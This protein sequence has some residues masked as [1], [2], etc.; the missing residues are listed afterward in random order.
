MLTAIPAVVAAVLVNLYPFDDGAT[1]GVLVAAHLPVVLWF[2][3][4]ATYTGGEL[5][6]DERRMDVVRFTGEWFIY[7]VLLALGGGVL[8]GLTAGILEPAG[9]D[10][11]RVIEWVL[12]MG[13]AGAVIVAAWLVESKQRVVENMAPVL[14]V[15]FTPLFALML[16]VAAVVY[17]VTGL[18]AGFDRE[19]L[20]VFDVLMVVVL[21]LVLYGMSARESTAGPGWIDRVQLAAV[22]SALVLDVIVLGAMLSR[23]GDL[24][25]TPGPDR[26]PRPQPGPPGGPRRRRVVVLAVPPRTGDL[27]PARTVADPLPARV[28]RLGG[29]RRR[30]AP[31]AVLLPLTGP[32]ARILDLVL[33]D[34]DRW[35]DVAASSAARR[36]VHMP[37]VASP[38]ATPTPPGSLVRRKHLLPGLMAGTVTLGLA[39][40]AAARPDV[41]RAHDGSAYDALTTDWDE[42]YLVPTASPRRWSAT[43]HPRLCG[44]G[45]R[46]H[47]HEHGRRDP[48]ARRSLPLPPPRGQ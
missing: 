33:R 48:P 22:A 40:Q 5:G 8:M 19:L 7:Y 16:V 14:T 23:I 46:P 21:G 45:R 37:S 32:A 36:R 4:A 26:R 18:G 1:T 29:D 25:F 31:A 41:V 47:G 27:P 10:A 12:P 43:N 11:E 30:R 2:L 6:S 28:R 9:V 15:V 42:P 3:V 17:V 34:D 24:G 35:A 13:A 39:A 20:T 38:S 44:G